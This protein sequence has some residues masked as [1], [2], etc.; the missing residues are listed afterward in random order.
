[1]PNQ[2]VLITG[3]EGFTGQYLKKELETAGYEIFGTVKNGENNE[4]KFK[5]NLLDTELLAA[6]LKKI[7]PDFIVN[8]A[9]ISFVEHGSSACFYQVNQLGV[10]SLLEAVSKSG[11][12][13][14]KILLASSAL[15]YGNQDINVINESCAPSPNNDYAVSKLA[16]EGLASLWFDRLP[17]TIVRPFN[18]TGIGQSSVFLPS[19]IVNHFKQNAPHIE[20]GN[21]EVARDWSDVRDV[22]LCYRHLLECE[23]SGLIVN[24]CSGVTHSLQYIINALTEISGHHLLIKVNPEF[25]RQN[26]IKELGGDNQLLSSLIPKFERHSLR[27]TLAWMYESREVDTKHVPSLLAG[28]G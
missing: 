4:V 1:M 5:C 6:H 21:L 17:I 10:L 20:L 13:P 3:L 24:V 12:L 18:Y 2:R 22:A 14:L 8:L 28:E 26:E 23:K 16:M 15:V 27:A 11:H 9:G 19:K 7:K 25:V